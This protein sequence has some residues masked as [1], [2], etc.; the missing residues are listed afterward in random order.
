MAENQKLALTL[1]Y[2]RGCYV[3]L[4]TMNVD[5]DPNPIEFGPKRLNNKVA[6]TRNILTR[7]EKIALEVGEKLHWLKRVLL[8][9]ELT[10]DLKVKDMMANDPEVRSGRNVSD[11]ESIAYTKLAEQRRTIADLKISIHDG[12]SLATIVRAK[13]ADLKDIQGRLRDQRNL[14]MD[15]INLG[16]HWG[17]KRAPGDLNVALNPQRYVAS[18][19]NEVADLIG[20]IDGEL[21]VAGGV[22]VDDDDGDV[23]V[24]AHPKVDKI[25]PTLADDGD[26]DDD[27]GNDE[28]I[29]IFDGDD[30]DDGNDE[31]TDIFDDDA[32]DIIAQMG[33]V[34][35]EVAVDAAA[36]VDRVT[37]TMEIEKAS[38]VAPSEPVQAPPTPAPTDEADLG[39]LG[40]LA[41]LTGASSAVPQSVE[42]GA[43]EEVDSLLGGIDAPGTSDGQFSD[44]VDVDLDAL[45]DDI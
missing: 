10:F 30:D 8:T 11:R 35:G 19:A 5:L 3:E 2:V 16:A 45:L 41:G 27:G 38:D 23:V 39:V 26:D 25:A 1:E 40:L 22:L 14:C 21:H 31:D 44:S 15:E 17:A 9:E 28:D 34:M 29:N 4:A 43:D 12:T 18:G 24:K 6:E 7:C 37:P 20:S 33:D 42:D 36:M 13:R 32:D